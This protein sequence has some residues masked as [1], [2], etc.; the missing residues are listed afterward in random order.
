[1]KLYIGNRTINDESFKS[2]KDLEV[3]NYI[4]EDGE[5][6]VLILDQSLTKYDINYVETMIGQAK[7]KVKLGGTLVINDIDFDLLSYYYSKNNN[8]KDINSLALQAGGFKSFV[9][10]ELVKSI[11]SQ[12]SDVTI[13]QTE[14]NNLEFKIVVQRNA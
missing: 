10:M 12:F 2:I 11:L 7:A 6:E 13:L 14:Y 4:A 3:V 5:C 8:I 1:M 9:T